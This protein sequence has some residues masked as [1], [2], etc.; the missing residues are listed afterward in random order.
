MEMCAIYAE[1]QRVTRQSGLD[2]IPCIVV[3]WW[4]SDCQQGKLIGRGCPCAFEPSV[5]DVMQLQAIWRQQK[6]HPPIAG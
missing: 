3:Q 1:V 2:L 6:Y 4:S 5:G